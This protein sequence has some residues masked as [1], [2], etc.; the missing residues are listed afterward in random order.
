M[1]LPN[2]YVVIDTDSTRYY[3]PMSEHVKLME[4]W[5]Q[6][7]RQSTPD[8]RLFTF[9]HLDTRE[10]TLDIS[11]IESIYV[12][13][14]ENRE[15]LHDLQADGRREWK[16]FKKAWDEDESEDDDDSNPFM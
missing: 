14:A 11:R 15:I 12:S 5:R 9:V 4:A 7:Y 1:E 2:E 16:S 13:T 8:N 6:W 3:A 10:I